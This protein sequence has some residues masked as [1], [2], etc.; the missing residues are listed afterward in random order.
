MLG[1]NLDFAGV[2]EHSLKGSGLPHQDL[3]QES[4]MVD[5]IST[6][7]DHT[8]FPAPCEVSCLHQDIILVFQ[9]TQ[10][11][12]LYSCAYVLGN[13][14]GQEADTIPSEE[15]RGVGFSSPVYSQGSGFT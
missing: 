3:G 6:P 9:T 7:V 8:W 15:E 11:R 14:W 2:F 4:G 10:Q 5:L 1:V 13:I 12:P